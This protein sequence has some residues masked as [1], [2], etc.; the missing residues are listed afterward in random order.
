MS[1]LYKNFPIILYWV[2][3]GVMTSDDVKAAAVLGPGVRPRNANFDTKDGAMEECDYVAG[4]DIP[5]RYTDPDS[6]HR[7]PAA[8]PYVDWMARKQAMTEKGMAT[9]ATEATQTVMVHGGPD[10]KGG[11]LPPRKVTIA[12]GHAGANRP[13]NAA[14]P[15]DADQFGF[16][17]PGAPGYVD[18]AQSH[19]ETL[20]AGSVDWAGSGAPKT[21]AEPPA[22]S[23]DAFK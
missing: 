7:K 1:R 23:P 12:A 10:G 11:T 3:D 22:P 14:G 9:P 6:I 2:K 15:S 19:G 20:P 4:P 16:L 17:K 5:P 8:I 21:E 18:P 13:G